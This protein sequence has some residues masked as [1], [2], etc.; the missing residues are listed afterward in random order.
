MKLSRLR[1]RDLIAT[2]LVFVAATYYGLHVA[3][4]H[5]PEVGSVRAVSAVVFFLGIAACATGADQ[6]LF[7]PRATTTRFVRA[8]KMLGGAAFVVGI[9][10][11]SFGSELM[12]TLLFA[13]TATL[14]L[15]AT[16]R[17]MTRRLG[18]PTPPQSDRIKRTTEKQPV[19]LR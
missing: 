7:Q 14:W 15:A 19:R 6:G 16:L 17:H 10:A 18:R 3:D 11:I 4:V 5:V 1:P 12:L 13:A 9:A 2:F 8:L